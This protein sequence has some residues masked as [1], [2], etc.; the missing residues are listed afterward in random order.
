MADS[1]CVVKIVYTVYI[2][3]SCQPYVYAVVYGVSIYNSG[4]PNSIPWCI[5][6]LACVDLSALY[7]KV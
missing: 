1:P 7:S 3:G 4:Q 6:I 2:Y 5:S